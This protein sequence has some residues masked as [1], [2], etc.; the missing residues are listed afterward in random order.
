MYHP[1]VFFNSCLKSAIVPSSHNHI[2]IMSDE[3]SGD[4]S[5]HASHLTKPV[6]GTRSQDVCTIVVKKVR[7]KCNKQCYTHLMSVKKEGTVGHLQKQ[8]QTV[9]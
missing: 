5:S 8:R 6:A 7:K 4:Q 2:L 3:A 1:A 9:A